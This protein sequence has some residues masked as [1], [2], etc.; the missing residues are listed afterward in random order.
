MPLE[1]A[2]ILSTSLIAN[3]YGEKALYKAT[4]TKHPCCIWSAESF[5]NFLWLCELGIEL[6]QEYT[7]RYG[8]EHKCEKVI[9]G[10]SKLRL[11]YP[12]NTRTAFKPAMPEN[13]LVTIPHPELVICD[14]VGSYRNYYRMEKRHLANWKKRKPPE[15]YF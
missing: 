4:H 3:G 1:T 2:Q 13:C 14:I 6:C 10:Y 15:W 9:L 5:E 8:K 12:G 7:F 11:T